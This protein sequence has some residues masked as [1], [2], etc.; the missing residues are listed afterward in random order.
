MFSPGPSLGAVVNESVAWAFAVLHRL[1]EAGNSQVCC[2]K[3][4]PVFL[5][6]M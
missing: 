6:K 3:K 1:S 2:L 4:S 5:K